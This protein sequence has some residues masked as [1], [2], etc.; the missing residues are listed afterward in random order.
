MYSFNPNLSIVIKSFLV[1]FF[2]I[3]RNDYSILRKDI[4]CR[5]VS[6]DF[7]TG[8]IA[9]FKN[10]VSNDNNQLILEG[11]NFHF[12]QCL[13]R[14]LASPEIGL[15][16][17]YNQEDTGIKAFVKKLIALSFLPVDRVI[18]TF[19]QLLHLNDLRAPFVDPS[20]GAI[21]HPQL[22]SFLEYFLH[23]WLLNDDR[24]HIFNCFD[25]DRHKTNNFKVALK[26][27]SNL[28]KFIDGLKEIDF[29]ANLDERQ[30]RI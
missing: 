11:C 1:V 7:E 6:L 29:Q 2:S 10:F 13:H 23:Y 3:L 30:V 18:S 22:T 20:G 14:K 12:A 16:R 9:V 25:R 27:R 24:I 17:V 8:S 28:W 19:L 15:A 4:R 26:V 5:F 21:Q